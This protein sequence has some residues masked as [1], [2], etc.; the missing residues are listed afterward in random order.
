MSGQARGGLR[1]WD[2]LRRS[3]KRRIHG[4]VDAEREL[5]EAELG[6][7]LRGGELGGGEL[8]GG[9]GCGG[10]KHG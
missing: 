9:C 6:E 1:T 8:A 7:K 10:K 3:P 4:G 5:S 2:G